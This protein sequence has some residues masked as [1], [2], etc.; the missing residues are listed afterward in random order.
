MRNKI[1]RRRLRRLTK[2]A[3]TT[4]YHYTRAA[5]RNTRATCAPEIH[6]ALASRASGARAGFS[7]RIGTSPTAST[8]DAEC[9]DNA[10]HSV[11]ATSLEN[12]LCFHQTTCLRL[13]SEQAADER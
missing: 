4:M 9:V 3:I 12:E 13:R 10:V 8:D 7:D 5:M 11:N 1:G 2:S 6:L